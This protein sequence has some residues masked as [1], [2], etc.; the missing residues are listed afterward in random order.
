VFSPDVHYCFILR[1][2]FGFKM[3]CRDCTMTK[4]LRRAVA[5]TLVA[6]MSLASIPLG[7]SLSSSLQAQEEDQVALIMEQ[8]SSAAKVGQLFL[9]TFPG[10]EVTEDSA[11]AELISEYH[12]GGVVLRQENGNIVNEG[13]TPT[14][15]ATLVTQLQETAWQTTHPV[16]GTVSDPFVPLLIAVDQEGNGVP[17]TSIVNGVTPLPSQMALGATWNVSHTA[18]VGEIVGRE[19]G[20]V[21]VNVLLGPSLDVLEDPRPASSGDLGVRTFGGEPFWV[22]QM[23]KA[24]IRG[25]HL[26]AEGRMAV[27]AKH[28]PGLG[29]S[30]RSLDEEL[31]TVQRTLEKLKQVDLAPFFAVAQARD[32]LSRPDGILVSHI[33]FQGLEGG[34]FITTSPISVDSNVLQQLLALPEM[35]TW[36]EAGG[37]TLSDELGLRALRRFYAPGEQSFNGRRIAQDA[38]LAG[39]DLLFLSHFSLNDEWED[40]MANVGS[41]ITFF[42]E[43][44]ASEPSFQKQ[45]D[46][47]VARILRLKLSLSD[48]TFSLARARPDVESASQAIEP[49]IEAVSS[50]ARDAIT[51]LSPPS[52]DLVPS[53]PTR[54]DRIVIFTD[55]RESR[56]CATCEPVPYIDRRTLQ[57][58]IVQ[59]YGPDAT[60]QVDPQLISSFTFDQLETYLGAPAAPPTVTLSTAEIVTPTPVPPSPVGVALENADWVVFGML[61]PQR[62]TPQSDVVNRFLAE[63]ADALR[64]PHVVV[65]AFDAPYCLDATEISKLSAYYA[66]YSHLT[67]FVRTSV[68]ALFGEFVPQGD[69]PVTVTGISYDLLIRT[70]PDPEQTIPIYYSVSKPVREGEGTPVPSEQEEPAAQP[71]EEGQPAAEPTQEGQPTAEPRLEKGDQL[72]LHTGEILDHNGHAVP[73]GT[74]VQFV[75][76]YPQEGLEQSVLATTRNGIAEATLTLDRTGRLDISVQADPVP[77]KV[78]LQI[79]IQE[80]GPA[81]IVTPTPSPTPIPTP[82]STPKPT[83][84]PTREPPPS[85][86]PVV[87]SEPAIEEPEPSPKQEARILDLALA[88]VGALVVGSSGYYAMRLG[89][90][91]VTRALRVAL[92]C[93]IGGLAL[94]VIYV[95]G[96]SYLGGGG[97]SFLDGRGETWAAGG[98]ALVGSAITLLLAWLVDQRKWSGKL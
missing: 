76:D 37:V 65:M 53:P 61:N 87:T 27:V 69:P 82:T 62:G 3:T 75:F 90:R 45:V 36:R 34:R 7:G 31:S 8:M 24:Y 16:T 74:P 32:P 67:L 71:T 56:P 96:L 20:A 91:T 22:G 44:Y 88:L 73:D 19:L 39:N 18:T 25:V 57:E 80:G 98:A 30:D 55:A 68:R 40:Q 84:T 47:A 93:I 14:Q 66:A 41:T 64:D 28:F 26:G 83:P 17:F 21:G 89:D 48:G 38:F 60:G 2:F 4:L 77:R 72:R 29:S 23:G 54:E 9:V 70:S 94:Y 5:L 63:R 33:R 97:L 43:K 78:A 50:I 86:T 79:T 15:V 11:V 95:L 52:P 58:T 42:R 35:S 1:I 59:F 81:T 49:D 92:W 6:V 51:L 13:D 12:V 46:E 85:P 10:S